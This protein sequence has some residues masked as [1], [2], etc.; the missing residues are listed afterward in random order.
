MQGLTQE[1][2]RFRV[3]LKGIDE[4]TMEHREIFC[5]DFSKKYNLSFA[6]LRNV[7]D[8]C[9]VVLR[10]NISLKKAE[11]LAKALK[12]FGALVSIEG[13][14]KWPSIR[15]EF[16]DLGP[17]VLALE[18]SRVRKKQN[19]MWTVTGKVKNISAD[20][21]ADLWVLVQLFG[22]DG[23]LITFEEV[24]LP[25]NPL[26]PRMSCPFKVLIEGSSLMSNISIAFKNAEGNPLSASDGRQAEGQTRDHPAEDDPVGFSNA[27]ELQARPEE[28]PVED[29]TAQGSSENLRP[30]T[31]PSPGEDLQ[32]FR[33]EAEAAELVD[34]LPT[35]RDIAVIESRV[36]KESSGS[37]SSVEVAAGPERRDFELIGIAFPELNTSGPIEKTTKEEA[38]EEAS[39]LEEARQI[40]GEIS[41]GDHGSDPPQETGEKMEAPS[42]GDIEQ[43]SPAEGNGL[44]VVP[45]IESFRDSVD[46]FYTHHPDPFQQWFRSRQGEKRFEDE[47]HTLVTILLHA[48]F[49]QMTPSAKALENTER[50]YAL[51]THP[52]LTVEEIPALEGTLRFPGDDWKILLHKAIPRLREV[53][54]Y[55][56]ARQGWRVTDLEQLLQVIPHMGRQTSRRATKWIL[57]LMAGIVQIDFSQARVLIGEPLYRVA[58]RLGVVDPQ[59]DGCESSNTMGDIKIQSFARTAFPEDI[60]RIEEPMEWVGNLSEEEGHC[61]PIHPRCEGC[62]FDGFCPKLHDQADPSEKGMTK[63]C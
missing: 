43:P 62:L 25:I 7:I 49:D 21:V 19:G 46:A 6:L 22:S 20:R 32:G 13:N 4:D 47:F 33:Q 59:S 57:A 52:S 18:D 35:V 30:E 26:F 37:C 50:V 8:R 40:L 5:R 31:A 24:P 27:A 45:W 58:A 14:K 36:S 55:I 44:T 15:L 3:L 42:E 41:N 10:K 38:P 60:L 12:Q 56:L 17:S 23:E 29:T 53:A 1:E 54:Q 2:E 34:D 51:M 48:R 28:S 61:L 9:P 16:Q 39:P 11:A 63:A